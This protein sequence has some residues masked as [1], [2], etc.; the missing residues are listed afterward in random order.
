[1]QLFQDKDEYVRLQSAL[2]LGKIGKP[3]VVPLTQAVNEFEAGAPLF[4]L[5][6]PGL[7]RPHP[8]SAPPPPAHA[9]QDKTPHLP[10]PAAHP[11]GHIAPDPGQAGEPLAAALA[12]ENEDVR[13]A[14]AAALPKLGATA[15]DALIHALKH[16]DTKVR[17]LAIKTL[18]EIGPGA[19]DAL[20]QLK[21]YL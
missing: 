11:L 21:T 9:P 4:A 5:L 15:T 14:A 8:Q 12:D 17:N 3:A 2:A 20:P 16:K 19:K 10:P 13:K 18:G 6:A 7:L 1:I